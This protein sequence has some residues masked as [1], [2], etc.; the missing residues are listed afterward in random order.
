MKYA[1]RGWDSHGCGLYGAPRGKRKHRGLDLVCAYQEDFETHVSG[2]VTRLGYPYNMHDRRGRGQLRYV[3]VTDSKG[4]MHRFMY[5]SP[6]VKLGDHV[7]KGDVLGHYQGLERWYSGIT[8]HVHYE[9]KKTTLGVTLYVNPVNW[10]QA[11]R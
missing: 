2:T 8:P 11:N 4:Y 3:Q 5:I 1:I 10:L 9:I 6:R 7:L